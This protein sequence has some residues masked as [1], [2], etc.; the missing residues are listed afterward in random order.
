MGEERYGKVR[1]VLNPFEI[2]QFESTSY[3]WCINFDID[4]YQALLTSYKRFCKS[5]RAVFLSDS[6]CSGIALFIIR[7]RIVCDGIGQLLCTWA[8]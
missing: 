6:Y 8:F 1:K 2:V 4:F 3:M 7:R 5:N